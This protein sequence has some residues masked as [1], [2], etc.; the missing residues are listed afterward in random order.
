M[1]FKFGQITYR[2]HGHGRQS[3]GLIGD[4]VVV[5][6]HKNKNHTHTNSGIYS[7][8]IEGKELPRRYR[9]IGEARLA[10]QLAHE[11]ALADRK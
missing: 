9:E 1:S 3:Q 8:E 4:K 11:K 10:G 7:V 5:V 6:I 2:P